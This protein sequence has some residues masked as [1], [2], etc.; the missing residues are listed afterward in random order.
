VVNGDYDT[1]I[2]PH[3]PSTIALSLFRDDSTAISVV[4]LLIFQCLRHFIRQWQWQWLL[5]AV[6]LIVLYLDSPYESMS[7]R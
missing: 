7:V 2:H 5:V 3:S 4:P 1:L 6:N